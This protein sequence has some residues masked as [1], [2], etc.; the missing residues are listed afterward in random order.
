MILVV[1]IVLLYVYT[2]PQLKMIKIL[3]LK[4]CRIV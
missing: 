3:C 4:T 2:D 1:L